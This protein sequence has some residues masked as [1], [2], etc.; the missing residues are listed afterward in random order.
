MQVGR[1]MGL[2]LT[3]SLLLL[4][5]CSTP[6]QQ[7][8]AIGATRSGNPQ[9]DSS[10]RGGS[11]GSV[12]PQS[13]SIVKRFQDAAPQSRTAVESAMELIEKQTELSKRAADLEK[14]NQ[15]LSAENSRLKAQ[16]ASMESELKQAQKELTEANDLLV[17]M[18]VEL[19][20]WKSDILGFRDEMR[21]AEMAQL[22]SL[23]KILKVLGGEVTPELTAGESVKGPDTDDTTATSASPRQPGQANLDKS[24]PGEN[25]G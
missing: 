25:N 22:E 12:D 4:S 9:Q 6:Q 21:Q 14:T 1:K 15:G 17:E 7:T 20:N 24:G 18:R 5:G 23:L 13:S 2:F 19:N 11:S 3:V 16:V 8:G 10:L